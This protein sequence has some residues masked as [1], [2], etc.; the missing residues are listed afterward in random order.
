MLRW[1]A[2]T[3][4]PFFFLFYGD[5]V[6]RITYRHLRQCVTVLSSYRNNRPFCKSSGKS[7]LHG[8]LIF[9]RAIKICLQ[10][11]EPL[12]LI[13]IVKSNWNDSK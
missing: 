9:K 1:P 13:C 11:N 8:T 3:R 10:V 2:K 6:D 12:V 5:T 7:T 4:Q